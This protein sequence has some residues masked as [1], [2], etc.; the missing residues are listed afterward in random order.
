MAA[1]P[2]LTVQDSESWILTLPIT[3]VNTK[4]RARQGSSLV[5][6]TLAI[7]KNAIVTGKT[8]P[9]AS[10]NLSL[11]VRRKER[12]AYTQRYPKKNIEI[13]QVGGGVGGHFRHS[14]ADFAPLSVTCDHAQFPQ[15][16]FVR[17]F[18]N[19]KFRTLFGFADFSVT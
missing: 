2:S 16:S 5:V 10:T 12:I 8:R 15:L 7:G 9:Y 19:T 14:L 6:H 4:P 13:V 3:V 17:T 11:F 1:E 18:K